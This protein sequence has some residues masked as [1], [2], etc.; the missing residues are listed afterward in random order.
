[1]AP[2]SPLQHMVPAVNGH[3]TPSHTPKKAAM[4][5]NVMNVVLGD[6]QIKPWYPSFYP[7]E[8]I[9]KRAERLYVCNRCFKYSKEVMP[10]LGHLVGDRAPVF[11]DRATD[12]DARKRVCA[13]TEGTIPGVEVYS[14][15]DIAI[16][17]VDGEDR[18]VCCP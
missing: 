4:E 15:N 9:G 13:A 11:H 14:A 6:L 5:P 16:Y 1:M 10:Y 2:A 17:E 18:K 3:T 12:R 7:E 8:I